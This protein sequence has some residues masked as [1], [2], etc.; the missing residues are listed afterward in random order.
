MTRMTGNLVFA[1]PGDIDT[2]TG[3][4]AYDRELMT[5]LRLQGREITHLRLGDSFPHP[6]PADMAHASRQLAAVPAHSVLLVDGLALG[7]FDPEEL[8]RVRAPIVALVHHPLAFEGNLADA[9]LEALRSIE[10]KNL[11]RSVHVIVTSSSTADL[12]QTHYGVAASRITVARPGIQKPAFGH[13]PQQPP[14]IISVGSLVPRKGHDVL[15]GALGSL[16]EVPWQAAI[17]GPA[18]DQA[19]ANQLR[20][21]ITAQ[22]LENQVRL[23]GS[24]SA[25]D[26]DTLYRQ[27][28][29]FALATRFEGHG[30]VFDEAMAYGL[31]IVSCDSG[32]VA[33]TV[34]NSAAILVPADDA[35]VF[36]DALRRVLT[37][38]HL[39]HSMAAA[40]QSAGFALPDWSET[41]ACVASVLDRIMEGTIE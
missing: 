21:L 18:R 5:R 36:G 26:L 29:V 27:A 7:A 20:Q 1:I 32:A 3:G 28:S 33:D 12:L 14:L 40:S 31:P 30:M 35:A 10:Q 17:V 19:Y 23:L 41:A 22:G 13:K 9:R 2:P 6:T 38:E 37:D 16:S 25:D 24:V 34:A 8:A 4:Y 11:A 15:I 39:R